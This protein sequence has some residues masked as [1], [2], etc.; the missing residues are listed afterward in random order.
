[1]NDLLRSPLG[2]ALIL[3][4][5]A[6]LLRVFSSPRRSSILAILTLVPLSATFVLLMI[7][8]GG[9]VAV[10]EL[11]W[12]PLVVPPLRV[13]WALD[14]WNWLALVLLLIIGGCAVLLTWRLPGKRSGAFHGL[15]F[16]LLGVAALTVVSD[17]LLALSGAWVATD[18]L[19]VA[20]ARGSRAQANPAPVWLEA[21]G[22][23]LML[24]AIGITSINV[25]TTTLAAARLPDETMALL[26]VIAALR[27]AAYP[28]HLWLAPAGFDRDRGTQLLLNG[29][30]LITGAW[31]LGRVFSLGAGVWL[32]NPVWPPLLT[33]LTLIAGLVAWAGSERDRLAMLGGGRATW[34]WLV[35]ALT[36]TVSGR[37]ALGWGLVSVV[38]GLA[39]LAVG[40][41]VNEQWRWRIPLA[42][43]AAT[44]AGVPLTTGMPPRALLEPPNLVLMVFIVVADGLAV[45]CVLDGW[46]LPQPMKPASVTL[47]SALH[48]TPI[49]WRLVRLLSAVG[50]A[51]VPNLLWGLQPSSLASSAGFNSAPSFWQLLAQFGLLQFIAVGLAL[52]LGVSLYQLAQQPD[53]QLKRGRK[54]LATAGGLTWALDGLHWLLLWV[55]VAWRNALLI[56]E[57]EGYLGWVVLLLLLVL[58]VVQL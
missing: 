52:A 1:M 49:N 30:G 8:R 51:V 3:L 33:A 6:A 32:A 45:A 47:G 40:Q 21:G 14:G 39:L 16:A 44:L 17:N 5:A 31:L 20:R 38:L 9:G 19:L 4:L 11:V 48:G 46:K 34:L 54:R 12:W 53:A 25:A 7:L 57:G 29:L 50:L 36:P 26:L 43:A 55:A 2:P 24:V 13:L 58:L 18:I 35:V 15:S 37:D 56:V 28:L 23:L 22:S 27:M 41:A 10:R 42:L